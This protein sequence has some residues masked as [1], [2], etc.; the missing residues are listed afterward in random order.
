M[1]YQQSVAMAPAGWTHFRIGDLDRLP[2]AVKAREMA[3]VPDF[4]REQLANGDS[5]AIQRLLRASFWTFVYH[6]EPDLWDRLSRAEPIR[7]ELLAALP[8]TVHRALDVGAGSGRLTEHLLG[9]SRQVVAV[10]PSLGLAGFLHQRLPA[11]TVVAGWA[12]AL[13]LRDRSFQLTAAAGSF[14]PD[15]AVLQELHRV[16]EV[17]GVIA[18]ISPESPDWF[19]ARGWQRLSVLRGPAP[20]HEPWIDAFFGPPEPLHE[21]VMTR[22]AVTSPEYR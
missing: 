5:D 19:E 3:R 10:E 15:L 22:V 16:T 7:P 18:L 4:E 20:P 8:E 2:P 17:G 14:G 6:L 21:L 11:A 12:E 13:P 1:D 9:R